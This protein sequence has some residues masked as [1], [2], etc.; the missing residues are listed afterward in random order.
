MTDLSEQRVTLRAT[1]STLVSQDTLSVAASDEGTV[2]TY[3]ARLDLLGVWRVFN[4]VLGVAFR[5]LAAK[6]AEGIRRQLGAR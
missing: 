3:D 1:T 6:A 4:P 5:S 2:F